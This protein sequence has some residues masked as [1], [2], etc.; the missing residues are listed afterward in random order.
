MCT[1]AIQQLAIEWSV[2]VCWQFL[3]PFAR[4]M[5]RPLEELMTKVIVSMSE[6]SGAR[7]GGGERRK[8]ERDVRKGGVSDTGRV[9]G[10]WQVDSLIRELGSNVMR[11]TSSTTPPGVICD[12]LDVAWENLKVGHGSTPIFICSF[13]ERRVV[14]EGWVHKT[15]LRKRSHSRLRWLHPFIHWFPTNDKPSLVRYVPYL[16]LVV[17]PFIAPGQFVV[18]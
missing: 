9:I 10:W 17:Y 3:H 8:N 12:E 4:H 15:A 16:T 6:G 2:F 13:T 5:R 7:G 11:G 18:R 14:L 1:G